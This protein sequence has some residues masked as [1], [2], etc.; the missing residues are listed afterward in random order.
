VRK[1]LV[2]IALTLLMLPSAALAAPNAYSTVEGV[3]AQTG[4]Q[5]PTCRFSNATLAA[6]LKQA[7]NYDAEYLGDFSDTVQNV[8][9][10]QAD[11]ACRTHARKLT[12]GPGIGGGFGKLQP[13]PAVTSGTSGGL[14]LPIA[15]ILLIAA[16]A[17]V[18]AAVYGG[19]RLLGLEPRWAHAARQSLAEAEDRLGDGWES[20]LD[21]LARR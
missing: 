11:G 6:A 15:L 21:R 2:V 5:I 12:G 14:P 8:M 4:G 18:T 3:Y 20:L 17:A 1:S 16:I 13:P 19:F 9:S 10:R 7:P